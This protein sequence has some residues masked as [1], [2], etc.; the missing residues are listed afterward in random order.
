MI[1]VPSMNDQHD[2]SKCFGNPRSRSN[3]CCMCEYRQSCALFAATSRSVESRSKL[4]S[5]EEIQ[6]WLPDS[7][8]FDH[9]PGE[10]KATDRHSRLISMLGRFFR[11]LIG[12]DDYTIGIICEM[13]NSG[14]ISGNYTV[15]KL[16]RLR[17]CSRQTMHRKLLEIIARRPELSSLLQGTMYKLSRG[18]QRFMR[19]QH[20]SAVSKV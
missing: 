7:A 6:S 4:T 14:N 15:S 20:N 12:L 10:T 16:S 1:K 9:I 18:R 3:T 17:G 5:F 13:L 8:D 19:N 11:Y 2:V